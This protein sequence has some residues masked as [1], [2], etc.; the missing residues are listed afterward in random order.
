MTS[1]RTPAL[2][3]TT[4]FHAINNVWSSNSGHLIEGDSDGGRG[5][6]EGNYID[7]VPTVVVEGFGGHLFSSEASN[8]SQ[9]SASLGRDCV[10]NE[11]SSSGEFSYDD[12]SFF[13]DFEGASI[14]DAESASS[15]QSTV[16]EQAGN[17]L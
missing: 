14:P 1:G 3:G 13:S 15:I 2:S 4:L 12:T 8:V 10:P 11:L 9:C 6:Y 7:N 5:L 16:P 17:T